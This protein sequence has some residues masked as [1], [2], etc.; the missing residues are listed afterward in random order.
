MFLALGRDQSSAKPIIVQV[1]GSLLSPLNVVNDSMGLGFAAITVRKCPL[2][3]ERLEAEKWRPHPM[4]WFMVCKSCGDKVE[5]CDRETCCKGCGKGEPQ[6][7]TTRHTAF[8][9]C[10]DCKVLLCNSCVWLKHPLLWIAKQSSCV[11]CWVQTRSRSCAKEAAELANR[12]DRS[13]NRL[14][15]R[16]SILKQIE[17]VVNEQVVR[18]ISNGQESYALQLVKEKWISGI[19]KKPRFTTDYHSN[20]ADFR[21][22]TR[23][24]IPNQL[25]SNPNWLRLT[26]GIGQKELIK[27]YPLTVKVVVCINVR[28]G[29]YY[30]RTLE[31]L[32]AGT[33][34]CEYAGVV[35]EQ[36]QD[37]A[38]ET[39]EPSS[40]D[41]PSPFG[42]KT[43]RLSNT[44]F[45]VDASTSGNV[46]HFLS[47]TSDTSRVN[48]EGT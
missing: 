29:R 25:T 30:V 32:K 11:K 42:K 43:I 12:E 22:V 40:N 35:K 2:C 41:E 8:K 33:L 15:P 4:F 14:E 37:V 47:R 34:L 20:F 46:S 31:D 6:N 9:R 18:D 23:T 28:S 1:L 3:K 10:S 48:L 13:K 7:A 19:E 44:D 17:T 45:V 26:N 27:P 39:V 21:Y 24:Q 36:K 5:A 38:S 16:E